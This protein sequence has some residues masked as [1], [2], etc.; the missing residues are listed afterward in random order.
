MLSKSGLVLRW[1]LSETLEPPGLE[2]R[3]NVDE[4]L[5]SI[6]FKQD[7][8]SGLTNLKPFRV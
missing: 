1:Y 3:F 5:E 7:L 4:T 6:N 8:R 2:R